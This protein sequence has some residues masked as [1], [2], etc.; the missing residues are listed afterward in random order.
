MSQE[1]NEERLAALG[2]RIDRIDSNVNEVRVQLSERIF[3]VY[4]MLL[5]AVMIAGIVALLVLAAIAI[6]ANR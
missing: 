1:L 2:R 6:A 5:Q 3:G 4:Q